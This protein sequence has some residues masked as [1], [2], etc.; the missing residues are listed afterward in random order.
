M[1]LHAHAHAHTHTHMHT[2]MHMTYTHTH[3]HVQGTV[4]DIPADSLIS[5]TVEVSVVITKLLHF[6]GSLM[7]DLSFVQARRKA[8]SLDITVLPVSGHVM[9]SPVT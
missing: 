9:P 4:A 3:A 6:L 1:H 7:R 5:G 8:A 2:H